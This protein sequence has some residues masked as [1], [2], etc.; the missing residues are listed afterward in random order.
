[1]AVSKRVFVKIV[2]M[3]L[4]GNDEILKRCDLDHDLIFKF[5]LL[6]LHKALNNWQIVL[7]NIVN[8]TSILPADVIALFI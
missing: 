6:Y 4:L 8:P 1:M 7:A 5:L 2:L 3:I